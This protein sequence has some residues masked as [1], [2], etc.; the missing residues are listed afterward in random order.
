[1]TTITRREHPILF[2]GP[3][4]R[5]I[6]AGEKTQTRRVVK[7]NG[8]R[9]CSHDRW[10]V[11]TNNRQIACPYGKPGDRLWVRERWWQ[12]P[13]DGVIVFDAD[14][15][16]SFDRTS[17]A[18][19]LG[20]RNV[21]CSGD[22]DYAR[23][24]FRRRPSIHM[25]RWVSRI[26][27][28]ILNVRAQLL[29]DISEEDAIAEGVDGISVDAIKRQ[30]TLSRRSDFAQ[31][32]DRINGKRTGCEWQSNPWVWAVTFRRMGEGP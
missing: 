11:C 9:L 31:L 26:T 6:L 3:M 5:A 22:R 18:Y 28:E 30:A 25:P 7:L 8:E 29:R 14:G 2:S 17:L 21:Q 4:V 23:Y 16:I 32:W 15:A 12:R 19:R 13:D 1:M 27:L 10:L 24:G 20:I